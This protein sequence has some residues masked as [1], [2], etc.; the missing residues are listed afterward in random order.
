MNTTDTTARRLEHLGELWPRVPAHL[1]TLVA[2]EVER[3]YLLVHQL[4]GRPDLEPEE[5]C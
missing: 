4:G 3:L 1:R 5:G 2:R